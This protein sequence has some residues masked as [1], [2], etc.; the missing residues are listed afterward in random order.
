MR[1]GDFI[2]RGQKI[3]RGLAVGFECGPQSSLTTVKPLSKN[4]LQYLQG[5]DCWIQPE[6]RTPGYPGILA[7]GFYSPLTGIY[8]K[9]DLNI[10]PRIFVWGPCFWLCT[11][12]SGPPPPPRLLLLLQLAHTQLVHTQLAHTQ[13]VHTQ[14]AHTQLDHTHNLLTHNFS[15]HNLSTHNLLTHNLSHT[16]C[17]GDIHSHFAWQAWDLVTSTFT[18]RGRRGTNGTGLALVARLVPS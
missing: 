8:T 6:I 14:L 5:M 17:H 4:L 2:R 7:I 12:A 3:N 16:T 9:H 10:V 11:P 18:L 15:T 13:L 1:C